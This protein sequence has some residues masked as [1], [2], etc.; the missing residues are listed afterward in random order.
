LNQLAEITPNFIRQFLLWH[1]E[2]G[3]NPGGLHA[4]FRV[5]RTFLLWYEDE[6]E[7]DDWKN[8][9]RKIRHPKVPDKP[10]EP[11]DLDD[12]SSLLSACKG[13]SLLDYRD[14]AVIMF[15]LD[16]G[17]RARELL[18]I[19]FEDVNLMS[20]EVL[21]RQGKGKKSRS[22]FLGKVSRK[23]LRGYLKHRL[24]NNSALWITNEGERL[25]YGGLRA[26]LA[27]KAKQAGVPA[28]SLHSFRRAF[29]INM[30]RAGVDV[31]SLKKADGAC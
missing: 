16:T 27:R 15:L 5:L 30:L 19:N 10:L 6:S 13:N 14:K 21:I 1:Q 9:I 18:Q 26:I 23:A 31:F 29:A 20:G 7:P 24:D 4:A 28:P 12:V 25:A 17:V 2:T 22:V 3:H 8:P 11:A